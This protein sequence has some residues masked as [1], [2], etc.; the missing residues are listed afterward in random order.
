MSEK[1]IPMGYLINQYQYARRYRYNS[2]GCI[3]YFNKMLSE[4]DQTQYDYLAFGD[5]DLL[6]FIKV[7][8]FR[9]YYDVSTKAKQWLGKRQSVLLYD[10]SKPIGNDSKDSI[11][12]DLTE[13]KI[14]TRIFF[15]EAINSWVTSDNPKTR[16]DGKF[17]CLSMLSI[18]NEISVHYNST[19]SLLKLTR[20]RIHEIIDA[21]NSALDNKIYC[22]VFGS[23]NAAELGI[24]F[25]SNEYVDILRVL[26]SIKHIKVRDENGKEIP[27]FLN[28]YSTI[29]IRNDDANN[30]ED[31]FIKGT[32]LVQIAIQ[33]LTNSHSALTELAHKI[34]ND[35]SNDKISYSVGEYDLVVEVA[36]QRA[37]HLISSKGE[38]SILEKDT[39]NNQ[40]KNEQREILRSNIRLLYTCND[41][42]ELD[43]KLNEMEGDNQLVIP[44][45][46][47]FI[48]ERE[49]AFE[50]DELIID[51]EDSTPIYS[52][53]ETYYRNIR[54][55]LKKYICSSAGAVDT[56]DMLYTDY[57]SVL[58]GAYSAIW[59]SD[60]HRQFKSVLHAIDLMLQN[61]EMNWD[62]A[63]FHD[64]TNAFKQQIYH[65]S[66][67]SRLFFEIPSC[68]LR[69]TGQYDFLMH[70]FYGIT[71]K[72]IEIIYRLQQ[73]DKQSELVPFI[74]VNTVP[75][76]TTEMYFEV[77]KHND[78]RTINLN[79]PNSI[80]FSLHRGIGYLTHEL[81]HYTVPADRA[82][83]NYRLALLYLS[84][85]FKNQVLQE[86]QT[87]LTTGMDLSADNSIEQFFVR[88]ADRFNGMPNVLV[89]L[90]NISLDISMETPLL[91]GIEDIML[92]LITQHY[93]SH[94]QK[95]LMPYQN[96]IRSKF[97][98]SV[99]EF[100]YS[101][102]SNKIFEIIFK[103]FFQLLY[104][105]AQNQD[106]QN[107]TDKNVV[108][109]LQRLEY[110]K[111]NTDKF[112]VFVTEI[113][114]RRI[115][116]KVDTLNF[117]QGKEVFTVLEPC[118]SALKEA[119][120]D[121]AMVSLNKMRLED[122]L[123][124]CIQNWKDN[125]KTDG[126][127]ML[128]DIMEQEYEQKLRIAIVTEYFNQNNTPDWEILRESNNKIHLTTETEK[129]FRHI[130]SWFYVSR[131]VIKPNKEFVDYLQKENKQL[132]EVRH[133][134]E[135]KLNN[136]ADTW[137]N[138]F[139]DCY[140][141]FRR[142]YAMFCDVCFSPILDNYNVDLRLNKLTVTTDLSK[143]SKEIA[144]EDIKKFKDIQDKYRE[145][146]EKLPSLS[147][148][149]G[150]DSDITYFSYENVAKDRYK[151]FM[152]SLF[153]CNISVADSFQ[154]QYTLA[155]LSEINCEVQSINQEQTDWKPTMPDRLI[156]TSLVSNI[157]K[158]LSTGTEFTI[159]SLNELM[160]Y[161]CHC[162][163]ALKNNA[164][165]AN[166]KFKD[167]LWFRGHSS[168]N[169]QLLPSI[170]RK[171]DKKKQEYFSTLRKY[172]L[173]EY[174]EFKF[175]ADGAAEMPTGV[176]FTQSDYIA[177]M[178]H[179]SVPTNFLDWTENVSTSLYFALEHYFDYPDIKERSARGFD[180]DAV[181]YILSPSL[182]NNV[183]NSAIKEAIEEVDAKYKDVFPKELTHSNIIPNLSTKYN[184]YLYSMYILGTEKF[185]DFLRNQF[186]TVK[187]YVDKFKDNINLKKLCLPLAVWTSRLNSRIR[188]QSGC[189][190]AFNLYCPPIYESQ[191]TTPFNYCELE[192][193]QKTIFK[194]TE[195]R[196]L[197][198]L[199]I[200]KSC[201]EE[202]VNWLKAMG[203][204]RENIYPELERLKERFD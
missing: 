10:I 148:F 68:H 50:K 36:V 117:I 55:D 132:Q 107:S 95:Y 24:V 85:I 118:R 49:Y 2:S 22:E 159:H 137:I 1:Y 69:S 180:R 175:R 54:R 43:N 185:D 171:Y 96:S 141:A 135:R 94:I 183:R 172:Q 65:L 177:L 27:V 84:L 142:D 134:T 89:N 124:F 75:Q 35:S 47:N 100:A 51:P 145:N 170:V 103:K 79:I 116:S 139:L 136:D 57:K 184:E 80:I 143:K 120:T 123:F 78:M 74:T 62:W 90:L 32:A 91:A 88:R 174:E 41:T 110:C 138:F 58:T 129:S 87:L 168:T 77:G 44:Y 122:Y 161:L 200:D 92:E 128:L 130:Y 152:D 194:E 20:I 179:Y 173:N 133:Y 196:Y 199:I 192:Q 21:I 8:T 16:I 166:V 5:F 11:P 165:T 3:Y 53:N 18:T 176:R 38:L 112:D 15:N 188:T 108:R 98:A 162:S 73:N 167:F 113:P 163:S 45:S 201:C 61:N 14:E 83:R 158:K 187:K 106:I 114:Q 156:Y 189:F 150:D 197:Y 63:E 46:V 37:I 153:A 126:N 121:I 198:K 34:A 146:L 81:F 125:F 67:S 26:D 76:V 93:Y 13:K 140:D 195:P 127:T 193:I 66:Q 109:F 86:L 115:I 131:R 17:F 4:Q 181:L 7:N 25:L 160:F 147:I 204:S 59:V 60:L 23:L 48:Q 191:K 12:K 97:E 157:D 105:Q 52:S 111:Q 71:K 82:E 164:K 202:I 203:V 144:E 31:T 149:F 64:V 6:E 42:I 182:Y 56:L 102:D 101:E 169:Y 99:I 28:C 155:K 70:T 9:E 40:Y 29:G 33:D 154:R 30:N 19:L 178:Q 72:I 104:I 151:D 186:G 119:C 39:D 190:V